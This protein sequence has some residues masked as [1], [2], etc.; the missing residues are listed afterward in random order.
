[1]WRDDAYLRLVAFWRNNLIEKP[2]STTALLESVRQDNSAAI[3]RPLDHSTNN[4]GIAY[5]DLSAQATVASLH[6][7]V[8][9]KIS[10]EDMQSTIAVDQ[11]TCDCQ[12]HYPTQVM[13]VII[14]RPL[15]RICIIDCGSHVASCFGRKRTITYAAEI[16]LGDPN[17]YKLHSLFVAG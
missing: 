14:A 11:L 2:V 4:D 6:R 7:S 5:D 16:L 15:S 12:Q 3:T 13:Q 8:A 1:M 17:R 9:A 10:K